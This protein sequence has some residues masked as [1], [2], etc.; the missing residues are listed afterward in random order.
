[1]GVREPHLVPVYCGRWE[2]RWRRRGATVIRRVAAQIE[3][4]T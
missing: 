2:R 1:L 3:D 4:P